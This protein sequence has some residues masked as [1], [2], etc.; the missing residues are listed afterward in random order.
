M[1]LRKATILLTCTGFLGLLL[2]IT[3]ITHLTIELSFKDLEHEQAVRNMERAQNAVRDELQKLDDLIVDW[4]VWDDSDSF[5]RGRS[6]DFIASNLNDRTLDSLHLSA[7]AFIDRK[8]NVLW[9]QGFD[10]S[11]GVKA[12]LPEGFLER[13]APGSILLTAHNHEERVK[14]LVLLPKGVMLLAS[15]P[16][17]N[18]DG[19]SVPSGTLVMLRALGENEG[20]AI[21]ERTRLPIYFERADVPISSDLLALEQQAPS[22]IIAGPITKDLFC[23]LL[24]LPDIWGTPALRLVLRDTRDI[25]HSGENALLKVHQWVTLGALLFFAILLLFL[26]RRLLRR[27]ARLG[28][29]VE[30]IGNVASEANSLEKSGTVSGRVELSGSDELSCLA[31]HI[32]TTLAEL[33]HSRCTLTSQHAK[34]QEQESY[35]QQILDSIQAGVLLIDPVTHHIREI[36]VFAANTVGHP[37]EEIIGKL[38]HG[39]ICPND[40]GKCPITDLGLSGEQAIRKILRA[41]G[42]SLPV[43]KTVSHIERNGSPLLLET[44]IEVEKLQNAQEALKRSEE[45][46]RAVFMNTGT[47]TILIDADA[48]ILLANQEFENIS[49][50]PREEIEGKRRWTEFFIAEDTEWMLQHH[51]KRRESPELAPRNYEARFLN[52]RGETRTV[53][54]T[55]GMIPDSNISVA[56]IEDVTERKEGEEQLR[57]QTLHDALTNLPNRLLLQDRLGRSV[58]SAKREGNEIAVLLMDLDRFKDIND[59][60]GHT[61]GD[62]LL[63]LVAARLEAAV[64]RSDTVARLGGD[65]FVLVVDGPSNH[66]TA[67]VVAQQIIECLAQPFELETQSLHVRM[68]IGIALFPQHGET[69]EALLKNAEMAMYKAK[70]SGR[71]TYDYYT[72]NLNTLVMQRLAVES[73]LRHA[74]SNDGIEVYYQPKVTQPGNRIT[75]AEA[76]VRW[77]QTD[78]T[79]VNPVDFIPVA[80][81]TGLI[82]PLSDL[83]LR[84]AFQQAN[85]WRQDK[86]QDFVVAVNLSPVL[87]LQPGLVQRIRKIVQETG[88]D[89][90]ALEYEITENLLLD[91]RPETLHALKALRDMGSAVVLDD[92]GKEYSSLS[93]IR[94]L[95]ITAIKIDRSFIAG[96]PNDI[97]DATIVVSVL[98]LAKNLELH[99]VAEGVET[100]DQL[101]FLV[102]QGCT[103]FQGYYFSRPLPQLDMTALLDQANPFGKIT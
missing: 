74:L 92:F 48:T 101:D 96:L 47:A 102:A 37:R 60:L 18:S 33:E 91:N 58:E 66:D 72:T 82:V 76:L 3:I 53:F 100:K 75:G 78:G 94:K 103:E 88:V 22:G 26:E 32:N 61:A 42:S 64:R 84:K 14:G 10:P 45:T 56:S 7:I 77:R 29:Q 25:M 43:L 12:A 21:A 19:V 27:L 55:V 79:L 62:T 28:A 49:G 52:S 11:K 4:A 34:T 71:N 95:P 97:S 54:M 17:T 30:A 40:A 59:S 46:Y 87:F 31:Q 80:E 2:A 51:H 36:N 83:V 81:N 35:L 16:I 98:N 50:C 63:Q 90:M 8:G 57:H 13:L 6:K 38:C 24:V 5:M 70:Q 15:C 9:A 99:V 23:G 73:G 39:F 89:P 68:S 20:V 93:Y 44:F 1:T 67:G 86:R 41:D 65:E 85:T 69:P